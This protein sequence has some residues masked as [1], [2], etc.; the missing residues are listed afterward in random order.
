[1]ET[2]VHIIFWFQA[3]TNINLKD[4][5]WFI[6]ILSCHRV[7]SQLAQTKPPSSVFALT[8]SSRFSLTIFLNVGLFPQAADLCNL[9]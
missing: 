9:I 1:M 4:V 7:S 8:F 5:L 6:V 3:A 2:L